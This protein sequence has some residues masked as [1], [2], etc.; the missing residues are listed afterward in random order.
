MAEQV[1]TEIAAQAFRPEVD[2]RVQQD[3]VMALH[4]AK[5]QLHPGIREKAADVADYYARFSSGKDARDLDGRLERL[6]RETKPRDAFDLLEPVL[7]EMELMP[8]EGQIVLAAGMLVSSQS[9]LNELAVLMLLHSDPQV[10]TRLPDL[11]REPGCVVKLSP[12][13]LRRLIG[14]RNWLPAAERPGVDALIEAIRR[15]GIATAPLPW[16]EPLGVQVSPFDG[17]GGHRPPG[18]PLRTGG[19]I[20]SRAFWSSRARVCA[21]PS[22]SAIS[23]SASS[24]A[25]DDA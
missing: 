23:P 5:L 19:A 22:V 16:T 25:W 4:G 6:V 14:L 20:A 8:T 1:Q 10:R 24:T 21:R 11:Y 9:L 3:L 2:V 12:L 17:S 15:T 13:G 7:A 18:W